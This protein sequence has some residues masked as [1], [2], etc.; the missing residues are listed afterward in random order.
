MEAV[1]DDRNAQINLDIVGALCE[2]LDTNFF[3]ILLMFVAINVLLQNLHAKKSIQ[4]QVQTRNS[5]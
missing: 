2:T 1:E 4:D 5:K 3:F